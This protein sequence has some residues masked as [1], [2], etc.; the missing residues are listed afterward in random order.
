MLED[1]PA[2]LND[3]STRHPA[4]IADS[5]LAR[6]AP[7]VAPDLVGCVLARR[8][9]E[10]VLRGAIVETEAYTADDPACHAYRRQT[11]RNAAMFG[12]PG[13]VYVY[14]IY[15][16]HRC[17]NIVTRREGVADAVL[18]RALWLDTCPPDEEATTRKQLD[19]LAAGPAKLCRLF[20]IDM[21]LCGTR[22][23]PAGELWIE[24]RSPEFQAQ[25]DRGDRQLVQT[26]R[27]GITRGVEIPWRWY[28]RDCPA[29]SKRG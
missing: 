9:G 2:F 26:T 10:T 21:P 4:P 7:D 28:L 13:L 19:R 27:I 3:R 20:G 29:V 23:D 5:W 14:R 1:L 15:G 8:R 17:V 11:D 18:V 12:A 22:L 16:I 25:L 6:P 24:P